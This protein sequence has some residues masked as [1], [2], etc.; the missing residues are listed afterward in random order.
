MLARAT[1]ARGC[2]RPGSSRAASRRARR[3]T[4]SAPI[5]TGRSVFRSQLCESAAPAPSP[6]R[7]HRDDDDDRER[8]RRSRPRGGG[9]GCASARFRFR[10][11]WRED[12]VEV[13]VSGAAAHARSLLEALGERDAQ[14]ALG[15]LGDALAGDPLRTRIVALSPVR[16]LTNTSSPSPFSDSTT[17]RRSGPAGTSTVTSASVSRAADRGVADGIRGELLVRDDEPVVVAGADPG[18]GEAD[19]LDDAL[20][21]LAPR[22][23]RRAAAAG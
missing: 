18:V 10:P 12:E 6:T 19:L 16:S 23:R 8:R 11:R 14:L 4:S 5:S 7:E 15:A 13:V 21:A 1:P 3:R 20:R 22:P 9:G 17:P 2:A